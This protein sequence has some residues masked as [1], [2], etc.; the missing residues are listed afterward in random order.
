M[1]KILLLEDKLT[2]VM[3]EINKIVP[4]QFG[5][6]DDDDADTD[7]I[8]QA[9]RDAG[10]HYDEFE[11]DNGASKCVA[12]IIGCDSVLKVPY[13][14]AW[15][16]NTKWDEETGEITEEEEC[17]DFFCGAENSE[18][19]SDYC[20]TEYEKYMEL[21]AAGLEMFFPKTEIFGECK[22]G[23]VLKQEKV[24]TWYEDKPKTSDASE[25]KASEMGRYT[26]IPDEWLAAA[27][28]YYGEELVQKLVTYC[29][30]V[31]GTIDADMHYGNIGFRI[32]GGPVIL[33][34]SGFSN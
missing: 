29:H 7:T 15:F 16:M 21:K 2:K 1:E 3:N 10:L 19:S 23:Y 32:G 31:D 27:I 17:F 6:F 14:G 12:N 22:A 8:W 30:D 34:F 28:E 18:N 11:I 25:K 5:G 26:N 9:C 33:D 24:K 13:S 4:E 20:L